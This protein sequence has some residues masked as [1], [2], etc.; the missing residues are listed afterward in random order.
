MLFGFFASI[1]F[2]TRDHDIGAGTNKAFGNSPAD[3]PSSARD[4]GGAT[5]EIKQS[6]EFLRV[7]GPNLT[8][9]AGCEGAEW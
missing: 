4:N 3:T 9:Q 6:V 2:P 5:G 8:G 7:H 1:G